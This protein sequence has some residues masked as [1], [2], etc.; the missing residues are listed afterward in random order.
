MVVACKGHNT[1]WLRNGNGLF[2]DASV[3]WTMGD[4]LTSLEIT[5]PYKEYNA[6]PNIHG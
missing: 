2:V 5:K 3:G 6:S 4:F 1:V